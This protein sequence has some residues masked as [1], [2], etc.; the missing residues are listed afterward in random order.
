LRKK[1]S[2]RIDAICKNLRKL[3]LE[4]DEYSDG[5]SVSGEITES[6]LT[7]ESF[8]DHRIAMSFAVLS[9]LLNDGGSVNNFECVSISNPYFLNQINTISL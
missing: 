9:M 7:F 2:D 8:D 3:G 1:E 5:F 6:E 4:V